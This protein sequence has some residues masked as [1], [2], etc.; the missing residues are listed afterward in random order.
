MSYELVLTKSVTGVTSSAPKTISNIPIGAGIKIFPT[1]AGTATVYSSLSDSALVAAD[2][3]AGN[4]AIVAG[5]NAKWDNWAA[6]A[7]TAATV[8]VATMP[9]SAVA[10]VVTSGTWTM[11]VT[12]S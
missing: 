3:L 8:L 10:L 7:V 11:E 6:G 4:A 9:C 1:S 12:K 5:T 2:E